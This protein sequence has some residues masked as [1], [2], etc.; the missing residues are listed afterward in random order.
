MDAIG[1][2]VKMRV[3]GSNGINE[4]LWA[5]VA[6]EGF[7]LLNTPFFAEEYNNKDVVC[8]KP[9]SRTEYV[10][11]G[12]PTYECTGLVR[13]GGYGTIRVL[14]DDPVEDCN[15]AKELVNVFV[16]LGCSCEATDGIHGVAP[17]LLVFMIPPEAHWSKVRSVVDAY[18]AG[19]KSIKSIVSSDLN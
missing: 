19:C 18:T 9:V 17:N 10:Q 14:F 4:V 11:Q 1:D 15:E 2:L 8:G 6:E 3:M 5:E 7:V 12:V 16:S 13:R